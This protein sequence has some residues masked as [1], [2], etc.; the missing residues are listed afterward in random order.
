VD[1]NERTELFVTTAW[2]GRAIHLQRGDVIVRAAEQRRG[3][4]RVLTRDSIASVKGTVFAVSAGLGGSVVSVVEGSVAVDQPGRNVI[5]SPG[6]QAASTPAL[7]TS[8]AHA[9]SWSPEAEQYLQLLASF[10]KIERQLA[11]MSVGELRTSSDLL[12]IFRRGHSSTAPSPT[13]VG[14]SAR[15]SCW[16]SSRRPRTRRLGR[17]GTPTRGW[18]CDISSIACNR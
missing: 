15:P 17:G 1:V 3:R 2:S 8:V 11:E 10:V 4:L 16:R 5:L 18:N 7:A 13:S 9:I 6:E 14:R 12:P